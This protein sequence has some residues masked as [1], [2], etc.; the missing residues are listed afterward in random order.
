MKKILRMSIFIYLFLSF[1]FF[2]FSYG[3]S[4]YSTSQIRC[5]GMIT[6]I[7]KS[8]QNGGNIYTI[9]AKLKEDPYK[10]QLITFTHIPIE[11]TSSNVVLKKGMPII[12]NLQLSDGQVT[13]ANFFD[14]DRRNSLKIL[15]LTF[16]ILLVIFGGLKGVRAAF[17]LIFTLLSIIFCLIPLILKEFNPIL[18]A[19]ITSSIAIFINFIL[20]SGFSKKSFCAIVSTIGGTIIAGLFAFYFGNLMALTGIS[21]EYIQAFIGYTDLS[22]DYRGLLFSGVIIGTIGA[23]MDISMSITSFIFEIKEKYPKTSSSSLLKS[24]INVGKD[25]MSTM[26]NTLILAYAGTSLPLFLF[27]TTMNVPFL[28]AVNMEFIAEEIFRSLCGSI[29][30]I[31]T[32]PLSSF[33]AAIK[34]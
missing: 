29:G 10:D 8:T 16:L 3:N 9:E 26:A 32:I 19:I 22:I 11:G 5:R 23:V 18:A 12:I 31:L 17:S 24:G 34:A 15:G 2:N 4:I 1:I 27:F 14:I 25:I 30:L 6:Q 13:Q 33:I 21:D 7:Q 28:D 20:I